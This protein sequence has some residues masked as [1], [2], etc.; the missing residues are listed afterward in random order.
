MSKQGARIYARF[1]S[2]YLDPKLVANG[3]QD[4]HNPT[5]WPPTLASAYDNLCELLKDMVH[6]SSA[7]AVWCNLCVVLLLVVVVV[8]VVMVVVVVVVIT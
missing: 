3:V 7:V 1:F 4:P 2:Q 6:S 8:V 5:T